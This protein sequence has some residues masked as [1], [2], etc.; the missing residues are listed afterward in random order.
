MCGI[1]LVL[2]QVE[3]FGVGSARE[4]KR[5]KTSK[6]KYGNIA[7]TDARATVSVDGCARTAHG[8]MPVVPST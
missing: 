4:R 3:G 1:V 5:M 6:L 2:M 7:V 8:N